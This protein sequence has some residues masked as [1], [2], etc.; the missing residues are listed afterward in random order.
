MD[1]N[2]TTAN[3]WIDKSGDI[4]QKLYPD[5]DSDSDILF[6]IHEKQTGNSFTIEQRKREGPP[7]VRINDDTFYRWGLKPY[8]LKFL[9]D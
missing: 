8:C 5:S 7:Y 9:F 2:N 6:L 3:V 4:W 1:E